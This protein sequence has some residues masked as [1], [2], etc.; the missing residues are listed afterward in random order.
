MIRVA[1]TFGGVS[2][3]TRSADVPAAR[4]RRFGGRPRRERANPQ[5]RLGPDEHI[6]PTLGVPNSSTRA[7]EA[8]D[9]PALKLAIRSCAQ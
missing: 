5:H 3:Q 8:D 9:D 1:T 2:M 6:A 7:F 4:L